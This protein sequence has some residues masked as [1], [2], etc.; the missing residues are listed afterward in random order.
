MSYSVVPRGGEITPYVE[1]VWLS[2]ELST[3]LIMYVQKNCLSRMIRKS[4]VV[5]KS[6]HLLK[7]GIKIVII[8]LVY[9]GLITKA[10]KR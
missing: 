2:G 8:R 1:R 10:V 6:A 9:L 3:R 7:N 4:T 5:F